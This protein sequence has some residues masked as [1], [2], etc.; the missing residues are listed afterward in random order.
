MVN[1]ESIIGSGALSRCLDNETMVGGSNT[2]LPQLIWPLKVVPCLTNCKS[3]S[4]VNAMLAKQPS[5]FESDDL[6]SD[7]N[8][9]L[10]HNKKK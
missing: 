4:I 9:R 8:L 7:V 2:G 3:K 1:R 5:L 10:F 6:A